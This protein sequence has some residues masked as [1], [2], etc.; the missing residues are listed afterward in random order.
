MSDS[1]Q[2]HSNK[3][4][5]LSCSPPLINPKIVTLVVQL[6]GPTDFLYTAAVCRQWCAIYK[7]YC[8]ESVK[9]YRL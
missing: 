5:K 9:R 6:T 8:V 7:A 3:E 1:V 4:L 2:M